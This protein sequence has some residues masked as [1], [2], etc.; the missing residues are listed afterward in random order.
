[1]QSTPKENARAA[2]QRL[3]DGQPL[4]GIRPADC[5]DYGELLLAMKD[6]YAS[7]GTS[8]AQRVFAEEAKRNPDLAAL[9]S[10]DD[11]LA[12]LDVFSA[13]DLEKEDLP[14]PE[15]VVDGVLPEKNLSG[16]VVPQRE[17][18][19]SSLQPFI[20]GFNLLPEIT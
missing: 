17:P 13:A 10:A 2:V 1:M 4:N 7:G 11:P 16:Y 9:R 14:E 6:A 3:L 12:A 5:G 8:A 20:P 19:T 15:F 18:S